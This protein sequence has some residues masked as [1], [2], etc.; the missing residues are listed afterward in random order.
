MIGALLAMPAISSAATLTVNDDTSSSDVAP[1]GATCGARDHSTI[2]AA[3]GA[4]V[5]GGTILVCQGT[6]AETVTVDRRLSIVGARGG[7]DA[8][9]RSGAE[10][11]VGDSGG[12][13]AI[14]PGIND[15]T[16]DGFTVSGATAGPGI[17]T[18]PTGRG[19]A[20]VNNIVRDNVF[21]L[22][23]NNLAGGQT[24]V[25][26]NYFDYKNQPGAA[27]GNA[28]RHRQVPTAWVDSEPASPT[29]S[30]RQSSSRPPHR[31]RT[32]G[33]SSPT[34]RCRTAT[35]TRRSTS[36]GSC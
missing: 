16:I 22:Y 27:Q 5:A 33:S 19:Q 35:R 17:Y 15:V 2:S 4:S 28:S 36:T 24:V 14:S 8:R 25:R 9:T 31:P 12:G 3:V 29:T 23:L 20:I 6:Y 11:V 34:T 26:H 1:A 32:T 18:P 7:V 30:T 10:S 21:G 13:F